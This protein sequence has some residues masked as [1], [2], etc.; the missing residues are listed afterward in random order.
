MMRRMIF[1]LFLYTHTPG[2]H[3]PIL[4][5]SFP[6]VRKDDLYAAMRTAL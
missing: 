2:C 5:A 3:L 4:G 6:L 1:F